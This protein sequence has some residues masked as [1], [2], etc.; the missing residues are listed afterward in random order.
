MEYDLLFRGRI[1]ASLQYVNLTTACG[2]QR[3]ICKR[4]YCF[5]TKDVLGIFLCEP[6][7]EHHLSVVRGPSLSAVSIVLNWNTVR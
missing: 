5:E 6:P 3:Q 1:G 4:I 2:R 7:T